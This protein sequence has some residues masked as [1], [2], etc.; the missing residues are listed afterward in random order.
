M[1]AQKQPTKPTKTKA[2]RRS[3]TRAVAKPK[4]ETKLSK[5]LGK[6]RKPAMQQMKSKPK[7]A[8]PKMKAQSKPKAA[9]KRGTFSSKPKGKTSSKTAKAPKGSAQEG[10]LGQLK[11]LAAVAGKGLGRFAQNTGN[12][13]GSE[14]G[15][16][17]QAAGNAAG[18]VARGARRLKSAA[19]GDFFDKL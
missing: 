19:S 7:A 12:A 16:I 18:T 8:T 13:I 9:S 15:Q 11:G 1:Y 14:M 10:G 2:A 5:S 4:A 17:G 3:Q 6:M